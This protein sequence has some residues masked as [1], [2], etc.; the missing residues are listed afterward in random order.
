MDLKQFGTTTLSTFF[1]RCAYGVYLLLVLLTLWQT[2]SHDSTLLGQVLWGLGCALVAAGL[3]WTAGTLA[4]RLGW[5][6]TLAGLLVLCFVLRLFWVLHAQLPP[7][8]DY[9]VFHSAAAAMAKYPNLDSDQ[10]LSLF[11][12][13]MG[14]S[15][16]L[17]LFYRVLG[18]SPLVAAVVNTLLSTLSC[19]L[20]YFLSKQ[21]WGERAAAMAG[22]I[23]TLF[24]SQILYNMFVLSEPLYTTLILGFLLAAARFHAG[25]RASSCKGAAG[26]GV[27]AG[28]LAAAVNLC[29]PVGAILLLCL[30]LWLGLVRLDGWRDRAW[31][32]NVLCFL[33][34]LVGVYL[35]AGRLG[36]GYLDHRLGTQSA[37]TPGYNILVGFNPQSGGMWNPEDSALLFETVNQPGT[38][39]NA[40]QLQ[41]LDHAKAR[42]T[43]GTIDFGKLFGDKLYNL[44][45]RDDACV[46]YAAAILARGQTLSKLC[47]IYWYMALLL[48][49]AGGVAAFIKRDRGGLFP[50]ML[51]FV[52]LILAHMLVE[53]AGRYHYSLLVPITL[54]ATRGVITLREQ[55]SGLRPGKGSRERTV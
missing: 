48:A 54:L 3:L 36:S 8:G 51:Y 22:L 6:V 26:W 13:V 27:L 11:P 40:A 39:P 18:P 15:W 34:T 23:W 47:N 4:G 21:L 2:L 50:A 53:V 32:R 41:M 30:L 25:T 33:L 16:F 46:D 31:R 9:S 14:Y 5:R 37:T 19:A 52:G 12:H 38:T 43:S 28:A 7:T 35:L 42:I 49:L 17:S 20:L 55:V 10:Y 44:M 24:P 45:G 29:R 1:C